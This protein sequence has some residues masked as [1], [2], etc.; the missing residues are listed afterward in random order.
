MIPT[1]QQRWPGVD[2]RCM[3]LRSSSRFTYN[4]TNQSTQYQNGVDMA[5]SVAFSKWVISRLMRRSSEALEGRLRRYRSYGTNADRNGPW[6]R[7]LPLLGSGAPLIM[8]V[9]AQS[10]QEALGHAFGR[11]RRAGA[12]QVYADNGISGRLFFGPSTPN[13]ETTFAAVSRQETIT[14]HHLTVRHHSRCDRHA[15]TQN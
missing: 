8:L 7:K 3:T 10:R 4:F 13:F 11:Q 6:L 9:E 5:A 15:R 14:F 2:D 1:I 12:L